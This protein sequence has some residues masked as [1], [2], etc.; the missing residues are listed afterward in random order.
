MRAVATCLSRYAKAGDS[1]VVGFSGG[2]DSTV[3][4][5]AANCVAKDT[6]LAISALHVHHGLHSNADEWADS[7][8]RACQELS[9]PLTVLRVAVPRNTGEGIEAAARHVR[10][11]ALAEQPIRWILLAHHADDQAE[12]V[13]HNLLRGAGVRGAAGMPESRGRVL[14][15]L[16]GLT[17]NELLAYARAHRVVWIED[18]S[19]ADR[20]YT[21]NFLRH[22]VLPLLASRFP[23]AGEQLAGAAGR[24]GEAATLLDDLAF[25]DLGANPPAF[26]LPLSLFRDLPEA[27]A[28]NLLRTMLAWHDVQA[29]DER[30]LTEFVRQLRMSRND[31]HPRVDLACYSLWCEGGKLCFK[32]PD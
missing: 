14:R 1:I 16:L 28:R 26:P 12:T 21:R 31:R 30:R 11:K 10:H 22:E 17:R 2:L 19:N 29:P 4:L 18:G 3:L 13:L 15:P 27:R 9:V 8:A 23:K 7:C 20:R 24:F 5:H 25:L 32:R 6:A